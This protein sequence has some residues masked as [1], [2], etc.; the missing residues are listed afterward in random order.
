MPI[1]FDIHNYLCHRFYAPWKDGI[2]AVR[3]KDIMW[4]TALAGL[5]TGSFIS[6]YKIPGANVGCSFCP[7]T[8]ET[9]EHLLL[10]CPRLEKY[11]EKVLECVVNP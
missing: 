9:A 10:S 1:D 8:L 3:D 5:K 6:G 4:R 11:R 7:A 2:L